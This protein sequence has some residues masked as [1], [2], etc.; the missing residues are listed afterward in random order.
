MSIFFLIFH[1]V[2]KVIALKN[3]NYNNLR[4]RFAFFVYI[5]LFYIIKRKNFY[6]I[7]VFNQIFYIKFMFDSN[8][9]NI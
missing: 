4:V 7:F 6:I 9:K 8:D 1:F 5:I 3:D 2:Q